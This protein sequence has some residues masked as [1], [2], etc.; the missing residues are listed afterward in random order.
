MFEQSMY[1]NYYCVKTLVEAYRHCFA[2]TIA[3]V[4]KNMK[5]SD[6]RRNIV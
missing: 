2:R 5:P 1:N 4:L 3:K 6:L